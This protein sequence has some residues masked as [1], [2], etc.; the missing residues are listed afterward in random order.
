MRAALRFGLLVLELVALT[1]IAAAVRRWW[2]E[3]EL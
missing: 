2:T 1:K 3:G